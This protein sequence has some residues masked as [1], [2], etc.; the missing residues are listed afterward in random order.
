MDI[1]NLY[2]GMN[3]CVISIVI[4]YCYIYK[5]MMIINCIIGF[6]NVFLLKVVFDK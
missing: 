4:L 5:D 2:I 6:F 1:V 3:V